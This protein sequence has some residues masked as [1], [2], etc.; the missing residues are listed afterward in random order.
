MLVTSH[1]SVAYTYLSLTVTFLDESQPFVLPF[2]N[3]LLC[4]SDSFQR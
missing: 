3:H 2:N 4:K 1:G